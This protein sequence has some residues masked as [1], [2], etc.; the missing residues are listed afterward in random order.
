MSVMLTD[1][2][3]DSLSDEQAD[4]VVDDIYRL[5]YSWAW[6]PNDPSKE[7][8]RKIRDVLR[9]LHAPAAPSPVD[10]A[11]YAV[12]VVN[13]DLATE[14]L[15]HVKQLEEWLS[16]HLLYGVT[17]AQL[18][19]LMHVTT[20]AMSARCRLVYGISMEISLHEHYV[21]VHYGPVDTLPKPLRDCAFRTLARCRGSRG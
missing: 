7:S 5:T 20:R 21:G 12:A 19:D 9:G 6:G 3:I 2:E 10:Y 17:E 1:E 14:L 11:E 13:E 8:L 16:A 15:F 4:R 18:E